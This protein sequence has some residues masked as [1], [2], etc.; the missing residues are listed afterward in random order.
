[1]SSRLTSPNPTAVAVAIATS[2][3]GIESAITPQKLL[4]H[5]IENSRDLMFRFLDGFKDENRTKQAPSLPNHVVW[6][7]GHCA[8]TMHKVAELYLDKLPPPDDHFFEG[9]G[10]SGDRT[11]F[12]VRSVAWGSVPADNPEIYP[13]LDRAREIFDHAVGHLAGALRHASDSKLQQTVTWGHDIKMPLF[14]LV[15]RMAFHNGTHTGQIVDLRR[16][17]NLGQVI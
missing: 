1:M 17:L 4:A 14:A 13:T 9:D 11:R 7:L 8:L 10:I 3:A 5:A 6:N 16:A 2:G 15:H 12:D